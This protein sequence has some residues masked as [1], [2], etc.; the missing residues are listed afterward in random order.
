MAASAPGDQHVRAVA[1]R[2]VAGEVLR[3]QRARRVVHG[4]EV[5]I[6]LVALVRRESDL[7]G[8]RDPVRRDPAGYVIVLVAVFSVE[9]AVH[10]HV[11]YPVVP[12][13]AH[14]RRGTG[15]R[16]VGDLEAPGHP[17]ARRWTTHPHPP[18]TPSPPAPTTIL[19]L[20]LTVAVPPAPDRPPPVAITTRWRPRL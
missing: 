13:V 20:S 2:D 6:L 5:V 15:R 19:L 7:P 12:G 10:A 1:P 9:V 14:L 3:D 18:R 4:D 17:R 8:L 11:E 16:A